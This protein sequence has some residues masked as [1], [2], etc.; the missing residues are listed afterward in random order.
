M[1]FFKVP[2]RHPTGGEKA[3]TE[4]LIA[5]SKFCRAGAKSLISKPAADVHSF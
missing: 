1:R 4:R 3:P 2:G 5:G